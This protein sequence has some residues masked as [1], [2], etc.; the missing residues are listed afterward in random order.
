MNKSWKTFSIIVASLLSVM[1]VCVAINISVNK[2]TSNVLPPVRNDNSQN[3][4]YVDSQVNGGQQ[5]DLVD[6]QQGVVDNSDVQNTATDANGNANLQG[7]TNNQPTAN[8]QTPTQSQA[9]DPTNYS[10]AQLIAYYNNCLKKSYSQPKMNATKVE[11]VDVSVSGI[12]I[13]SLGIDVDNFAQSII[14][15]NTKNNDKPTTKSFSNGRASDGTAASTFVLPTNLY[16]GAVKSINASKSGSGYRVVITL[17]AESCAHNGKAN[18]NAS[19]AWP[20]DVGVIDFGEAVTINKC[21]FNYPGTVLTA[22]IDSQGRV[23]SVKVEMPLT[24]ANAEA[25]FAFVNVKVASI[26]GKWTC[27]NTM[28]F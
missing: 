14:S 11:H 9:V 28:S 18:Y 10:K 13:G 26:S 17:N 6:S 3:G 7:G 20:L 16:D 8:N 4:G 2:V 23:T 5:G 21:T 22:M 12:D 27:N 15:N 24:V 25:K 1:I 19:C